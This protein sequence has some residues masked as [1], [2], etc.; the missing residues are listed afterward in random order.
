MGNKTKP[1]VW[2]IALNILISLLIAASGIYV[3]LEK[4]MIISGKYS[5]NLYDLGGLESICISVSLFMVSSFFIIYLFENKRLKKMGEWILG[6]A[7][8]LFLSSSFV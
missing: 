4:K 1:P 7:I 5:G 6:L 2:A 3:L 8:I